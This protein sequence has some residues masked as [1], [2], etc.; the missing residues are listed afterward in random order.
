MPRTHAIAVA[1]LLCLL[2]ATSGPLAGQDQPAAEASEIDQFMK[3]VLEQRT[4]NW[5]IL[6]DYIF[7]ENVV[8]DLKGINIPALE[9]FR[10]EYL[11][12]YR[13]GHLVRS[14][15]QANGVK[16]STRDQASSEKQWVEKKGKGEEHLT[17]DSFFEFEFEPGNYLFAGREEF[18]GH[19]V[20][21][22]E[23]YPTD[24]F[25]GDDDD[26]VDVDDVDDKDKAN[27]EDDEEEKYEEAFKKTSLVRMWVLPET[28]QLVKIT[29]ENVGLEFLPYRWLV[30]IDGIRASMI[31]DTP[32]GRCLAAPRNLR[33]GQHLDRHQ[34]PVYRLLP[35]VLE[36][37]GGGS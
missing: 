8:L 12:F 1:F 34:H 30:R 26:E 11:W 27:S 15:V 18:E 4:V 37:P 14:L 23:Y 2:V 5:E 13:D 25:F 9:S 35:Q 36:L 10:N 33:L 28:H 32:V 3:Q 22:I 6:Q 16:A 17:R 29:F 20:V 24:K 31:L 19:E 7:R 21:V